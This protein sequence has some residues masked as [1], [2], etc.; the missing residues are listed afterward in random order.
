[1]ELL[2]LDLP[3]AVPKNRLFDLFRAQKAPD[4]ICSQLCQTLG[5][6]GRNLSLHL[7]P[8]HE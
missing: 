2:V 7:V 1:M 5:W 6:G 4:L 3:Q 8:H